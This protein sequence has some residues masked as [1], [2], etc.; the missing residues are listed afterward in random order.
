MMLSTGLGNNDPFIEQANE[1]FMTAQSQVTRE[2]CMAAITHQSPL[3]INGQLAC[4]RQGWSGNAAWPI[5]APPAPPYVPP[6][7][8]PQIQG[9]A[10]AVGQPV[11]TQPVVPEIVA[12][13]IPVNDPR[14]DGG[15]A[16]DAMACA[17]SFNQWVYENPLMAFGLVAATY[18]LLKGA[19]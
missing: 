16:I 6:T 9:Q 3:D 1:Q 10:P 5:T 14:L 13:F 15:A 2:Q 11:L 12:P 18:F 17:G 7:I 19:K 4:A 8:V